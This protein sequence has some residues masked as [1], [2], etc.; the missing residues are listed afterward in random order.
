LLCV[1]SVRAHSGLTERVRC[2]SPNS[3]STRRAFATD[4]FSFD[5]ATGITVRA[6]REVSNASAK[7]SKSSVAQTPC[8]PRRLRLESRPNRITA[9]LRVS[10]F[11]S[12]RTSAHIQSEEWPTHRAFRVGGQH[13]LRPTRVGSH[14]PRPTRPGPKSLVLGCYQKQKEKNVHVPLTDPH[15]P[16]RG[17]WF[18]GC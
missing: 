13:R 11:R 1:R 17:R 4:D 9:T 15:Q 8:Y 12:V 3:R 6:G 18:S 5:L 2:V 16:R 7:R 10:L 14:G